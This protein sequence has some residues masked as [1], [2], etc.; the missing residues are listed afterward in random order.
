MGWLIPSTRSPRCIVGVAAVVEL[1]VAGLEPEL[2]GVASGGTVAVAV[3]VG[4][5]HGFLF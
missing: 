4:R 1:V 3:A 2:V 5:G